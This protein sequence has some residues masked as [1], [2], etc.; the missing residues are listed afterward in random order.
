MVYL[1]IIV[2]ALLLIGIIRL[3][4]YLHEM[5]R[6]RGTKQKK[7]STILKQGNELVTKCYRVYSQFDIPA[8]PY[9]AHYI[10]TN[11][12]RMDKTNPKLRERNGYDAWF[13]KNVENFYQYPEVMA[14][15]EY[16]GY[17]TDVFIDNLQEPWNN[18]QLQKILVS[19]DKDYEMANF[20]N[21]LCLFLEKWDL[22][23]E[24][25]E[26]VLHDKR[27]SQI[28]RIYTLFRSDK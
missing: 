11:L 27:F 24:I 20:S 3:I 22:L 26:I 10:V 5:F 28:R 4:V 1:A 25:K 12:L 8:A 13:I 16:Y 7:S 18:L 6:A 9:G 15:I 17:L 2:E 14:I 19:I 21:L 23:P